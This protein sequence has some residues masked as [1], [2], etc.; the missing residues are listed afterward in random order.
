M[1]DTRF[2]KGHAPTKPVG[3]ISR[4]TRFKDF[5]FSNFHDNEEVVKQTLASMYSN[6][7]DCVTLLR[8]LY[9]LSPKE[10]VPSETDPEKEINLTNIFNNIN[11]KPVTVNDR[12]ASLH[13]A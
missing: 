7:E 1:A 13:I 10:I 8:Y 3:A 5:M 6:K 4:Y 11:S 12:P 9:D 2:K